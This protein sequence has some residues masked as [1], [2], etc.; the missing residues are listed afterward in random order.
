MRDSGDEAV[1]MMV[2]RAPDSVVVI[3]VPGVCAHASEESRTQGTTSR[4]G[5]DGMRDDLRGMSGGSLSVLA[6]SARKYVSTSRTCD[7]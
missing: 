1:P 5:D 4:R 7:R 6:L 2:F 3:P